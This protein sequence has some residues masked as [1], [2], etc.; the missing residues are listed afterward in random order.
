[1]PFEVVADHIKL[2]EARK[3]SVASVAESQDESLY[4]FTEDEKYLSS[5]RE[6]DGIRLQ[7]E[8]ISQ[9]VESKNQELVGLI[10]EKERKQ[11]N[12]ER[13]VRNAHESRKKCT[14]CGGYVAQIV[15]LKTKE[16]EYKEKKRALKQECERLQKQ[17]DASWST[18]HLWENAIEQEKE[19]HKNALCD[20][21]DKFNNSER[22]V[23]DLMEENENLIHEKNFQLT[24]R[25]D[26]EKE[27]QEKITTLHK[28]T[29]DLQTENQSLVGAVV[30]LK[31]MFKD[32][33]GRVHDLME[34]NENLTHERNF[35]LTT[36]RGLE[37]E[38]EQRTNAFESAQR[39]IANQRKIHDDMV[40]RSNELEDQ[41]EQQ[42]AALDVVNTE[43]V[44]AR[45]DQD[46]VNTELVR[47]RTERD[48]ARTQINNL[49]LF[50]GALQHLVNQF[51]RRLQDSED[52]EGNDLALRDELLEILDDLQ[53]QPNGPPNVPN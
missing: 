36:R 47:V 12:E 40:N 10:A 29:N 45:A 21:E 20:L 11:A 22:R 51:Q 14:K 28:R 31:R 34:E 46:T 53:E 41:V 44:T 27:L 16:K 6:N 52:R 48:A 32:S 19:G 42:K 13:R 5:I 18:I 38:V 9:L 33:E 1:M 39:R 25:R 24:T 26:L 37:N 30:E 50:S 23:H 35:E 49:H 4:W 8:A 2:K 7:L 17:L 43:L 15:H 3:Q